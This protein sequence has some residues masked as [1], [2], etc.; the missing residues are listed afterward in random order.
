M[1]GKEKRKL[2]KR[3]EKDKKEWLKGKMINYMQMGK[4]K[5]RKWMGGP[6]ILQVS[7]GGQK[8]H[9]REGNMVS[10]QYQYRPLPKEEAVG[11]RIR[12]LEGR[13]ITG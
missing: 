12:V 9:S 2:Q 3:K 13:R 1:G 10:D 7:R 8:K 4:K 5:G 6:K 11:S